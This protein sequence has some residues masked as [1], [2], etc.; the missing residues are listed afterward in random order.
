MSVEELERLAR[1]H[2][3]QVVGIEHQADQMGRADVSWAQV[4][5]R[6]PDDGTGA[7]PLLRHVILNDAKSATYKLGLLR[8]LARAA[9]GAQGM[10]RMVD[11]AT[12]ALPLG[13]IALNW[14][15]L[16]KPLIAAGLPQMPRSIGPDGLG[17]VGPG[18]RPCKIRPPEICAWVL[19]LQRNGQGP[20]TP[21]CGMPPRQLRGC[22]PP[23]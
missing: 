1:D 17:F 7:L 3:A 10:A 12:I 22:R 16:Y 20:C 15:R 18:W 2:G 8:A 6:L 19:S 4:L 13:L 11:D 21:H 14:L 9:D 23:T 5:L